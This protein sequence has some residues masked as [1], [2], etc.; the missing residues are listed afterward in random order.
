MLDK[1]RQSN[2]GA[3]IKEYEIIVQ[4]V[5]VSQTLIQC[6]QV[7]TAT[8]RVAVYKNQHGRSFV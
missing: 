5:V 4:F 1:M 8:N 3:Q 2:H 7:Y 6:Q